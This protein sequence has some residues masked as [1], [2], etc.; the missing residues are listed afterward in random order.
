[1]VGAAKED[2]KVA[3]LYE[4]SAAGRQKM[5]QQRLDMKKKNNERD[6]AAEE[7]N[8]AAVREAQKKVVAK[9]GSDDEGTEA[10]V[11]DTG[12]NQ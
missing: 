7:A 4:Q 6:A 3:A 10:A 9:V 12:I 8:Y 11:S 1:M 5:A 2:P